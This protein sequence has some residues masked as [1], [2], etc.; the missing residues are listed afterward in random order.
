[1][2][3]CTFKITAAFCNRVAG[4]KR[5]RRCSRSEGP[6][7]P[8]NR[9]FCFI[10]PVIF[11]LIFEK[12][13]KQ[14]IS[15]LIVFPM[16][17]AF[18]FLCSFLFIN[19][20]AQDCNS[21]L[22]FKKG[23]VLTYKNFQATGGMFKL[24]YT[25]ITRLVYTVT[26]VK[27]SGSSHYSYITKTG[28]NTQNESQRYE[29]KYVIVCDGTSIAIPADFYIMDTVYFSNRYPD[30][31]DKGYYS[32]SNLKG[33]L[34]YQFPVDTEKGKLSTSSNK[35]TTAMKMRDYDFTPE[36]QG[37]G[38]RTMGGYRSGRIVENNFDMETVLEKFEIVGTE[39]IKTA[40]GSYACKKISVSG[41]TNL[42]VASGAGG[43]AYFYYS[44]T[45]GMVRTEA[46]YKKK[47]FTYMELSE[48]KQ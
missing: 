35:L 13:P 27:D 44:P 17:T 22:L 31:K 12:L 34:K 8:V 23:T 15:K 5:W 3:C 47:I 14:P 1:M 25:E 21:S 20:N 39:T 2:I 36:F 33:D 48:A 16:R 9:L 19:L 43:S 26:E 24:D 32:V 18:L 40:A 7:A 10:S 38:G 6:V 29:R 11:A 28:I 37:A 4:N 45:V 42:P 46:G 30:N 41:K